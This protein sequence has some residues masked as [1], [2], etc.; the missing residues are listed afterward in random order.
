M[1]KQI[2]LLICLVIC[3]AALCPLYV[4]AATPLDPTAE[5]SLTLCYQKDEQAFGELQIS[6]FRV[7]EAF[8]DGTCELIEPF[9]SSSVDIHGITEKE[10]W[11]GVAVTLNSYI[12]ANQISPYRVETTDDKGKA[13]FK[14]L[15]TGLYFVKEVVAEN[16]AGT[17]IFNQFMV[18][19]PT[20]NEDGSFDYNVEAKP[21]CTS[22]V[23]KTEYRVTKLWKNDNKNDRPKQ[24]TVDIYKDGAL[25]ESQVLSAENNWSYS[26]QVS[27]ADRSEWTVAERTVS[28]GYKV[29]IQQN[30]SS[31][32]IINTKESDPNRPNTPQTGDT[33]NPLLWIV[34][35]C[36]SGIL[37]IIIGIYSRRK[38]EA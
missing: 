19:L 26:W 11:Q 4:N 9:V 20:P 18:Y 38:S 32:S 13:I 10:Q 17:Y 33:A 23:P 15:E 21:K 25:F 28:K 36:L 34:I 29:T 5:A 1:R 24:I 27:E 37:L 16:N 2:A 30:G 8:S 6:I 35:T 12:V 7:A 22:F 31:F 3:V 14:Q